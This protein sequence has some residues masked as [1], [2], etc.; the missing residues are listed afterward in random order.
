MPRFSRLA[1]L[2]LIL[3][4]GCASD[5]LQRDPG[6]AGLRVINAFTT[7]VDVLVDGTV[8]QSAVAAGRIDTIQASLGAH[9]LV[10]RP[11]NGAASVSR[12]ID[13]GAALA[14]VVAVRA[15]SGDVS[16]ATLDDTGSVVPAG[17]TKIRVLHLAPA[18][19]TLQVYRIQPDY[20][21]PVQWQFPFD[22]QPE[23]TS[24][25]A[26]F[27]QSTV[28]SWEIRVWKTPTDA[29]GW[30]TA[31]TRVVIPLA[32]GEKKTVVMLDDGQGGIRIELL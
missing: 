10:L 2:A 30:S 22:Y 13:L 4:A 16:T 18:A 12:S 7:P 24:L 17:A 1:P 6:Q 5:L 14:T 28:G 19:G 23:P 29:S 32:S 25:S 9:T 15:S 31:P 3:A 27:V 11:T 26:P 8:V 20:P 21:S